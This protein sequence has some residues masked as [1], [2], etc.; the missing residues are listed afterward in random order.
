MIEKNI[1]TC[2]KAVAAGF[3]TRILKSFSIVNRLQNLTLK[4]GFIDFVR[5]I[6][7]LAIALL[8]GGS[9]EVGNLG[10]YS[11]SILSGCVGFAMYLK[12]DMVANLIFGMDVGIY[13]EYNKLAI[14][15][16]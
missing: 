4:T 6:G 3:A 9:E 11:L 10:A 12:P 14:Y 13:G 8:I 7:S 5:V 16:Y 1:T 2:Q 15:T